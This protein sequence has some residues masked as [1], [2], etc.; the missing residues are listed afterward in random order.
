VTE[1]TMEEGAERNTSQAMH[2]AREDAL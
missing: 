2:S 1:A